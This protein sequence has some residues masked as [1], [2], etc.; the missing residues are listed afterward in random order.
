MTIGVT[1]VKVP[2]WNSNEGLQ[3]LRKVLK[4]ETWEA[5]FIYFEATKVVM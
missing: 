3:V 4:G 2:A 1:K 5:A